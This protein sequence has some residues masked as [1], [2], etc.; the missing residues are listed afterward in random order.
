MEK[1]GLRVAESFTVALNSLGSAGYRWSA[2]VDNPPIVTVEH[3]ETV[4]GLERFSL[5]GLAPGETVVHFT[6]ARSFEPGKPPRSTHD[7]IVRVTN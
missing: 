2:A 5:T 3:L 6:Q 1:I 4:Q 7:V